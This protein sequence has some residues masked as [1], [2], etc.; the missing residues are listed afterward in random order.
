MQQSIN[1]TVTTHVLITHAFNSMLTGGA[2]THYSLSTPSSGN[3]LGKL[4][5]TL[6]KGKGKI[7]KAFKVKFSMVFMQNVPNDTS[8]IRKLFAELQSKNYDSRFKY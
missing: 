3:E 7:K 6:D 1:T 2:H 8:P 5:E 4:I